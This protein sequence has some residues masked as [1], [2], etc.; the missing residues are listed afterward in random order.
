MAHRTGTREWS[1][2]SINCCFGCSHGCLYC[3]A[4]AAALR[5]GRLSD[6]CCWTAENPDA[7]LAVRAWNETPWGRR[8]G[9]VMFPTTHD[10]SQRNAGVC[11]N[12][13]TGLLYSGNRVLVVSKAGHHVPY[14]VKAARDLAKGRGSVELRVSV[15]C[16]DD[17][18]RTFWEPHAPDIGER[19]G[20]LLDAHR[21]GLQ[22]SVAVEP[23]LE[24]GAVAGLVRTLTRHCHVRGEIWVGAANKLRQRTAWCRDLPG[25]EAEIAD[26]EAGQTP[27]RMREVYEALK[28][29]PQVRWKDSYQKALG[30]DAMGRAA[31]P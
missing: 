27:E 19:L 29:N 12:T 31:A 8:R 13:L 10:I 16:A 4:R 1:D 5:F 22:T 21:L 14:L 24:I 6:G 26:V 9:V 15:T 3:Y 11:L 20:S 2:A 25:M 7:Q 30:I 17:D 28:A 18:I 23:C